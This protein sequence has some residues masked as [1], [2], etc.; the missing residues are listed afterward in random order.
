MSLALSTIPIGNANDVSAGDD[1]IPPLIV[2]V[3]FQRQTVSGMTA[4]PVQS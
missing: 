2:L 3:S 1:T 4:A